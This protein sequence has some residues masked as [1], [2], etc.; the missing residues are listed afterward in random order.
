MMTIQRAQQEMALRRKTVNPLYKP[1]YHLSVPA[2][3]HNDPNGFGFFGGKAH[4][5]YQY[6]PYD[7][8]WGPMHWG[9]WISSDLVHWEDAPVAMAPDQT[10][11]SFGCGILFPSNQTGGNYFERIHLLY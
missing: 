11:D 1:G 10:F 8:V 5:F 2:G 7:S 6:H 3:W 9:H 4:L